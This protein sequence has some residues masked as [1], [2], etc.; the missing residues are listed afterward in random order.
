MTFTNN[1]LIFFPLLS[2]FFLFVCLFVLFV[3]KQYKGLW[4]LL[5]ELKIKRE[6]N[7]GT[8]CGDILWKC[9]KWLQK[10]F[11][12]SFSVREMEDEGS[13]FKD[14]VD[15]H[16]RRC[17][18]ISPICLRLPCIITLQA[19]LYKLSWATCWQHPAW[20]RS[21]ASTLAWINRG[22]TRSWKNTKDIGSGEC[23]GIFLDGSLRD[24][25]CQTWV[26]KPWICSKDGAEGSL[27]MDF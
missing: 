12:H 14:S 18:G 26:Q 15:L 8:Q 11:G 4:S 5:K 13:L 25:G 22:E 27:V 20:F 9:W 21:L 23:K 16:L 6:G 3:F 7:K 19:V 10:T 2:S 1:C 17:A 24:L